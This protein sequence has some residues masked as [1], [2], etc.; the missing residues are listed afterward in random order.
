MRGRCSVS[1]NSPPVKSRP[2]PTAGRPPAAG[3]SARH[4]DP[5]AGNYSRPARSAGAAASAGPARRHGSAARYSSIA[6][7]E[8]DR[9]CR[10]PRAIG[11]RAGPVAR[12]GLRAKLLDQLRQRIGEIAILALPE[13]MPRHDDA[14]SGRAASS[15][16]GRDQRLRARRRVSSGPVVA[17][18]RW[19]ISVDDRGPS[20]GRR[21]VLSMVMRQHR[22]RACAV[23]S[24]CLPPKLRR[25]R[26][27]PSLAAFGAKRRFRLISARSG[28]GRPR[29]TGGS[30]AGR[31]WPRRRRSC[32]SCPGRTHMN[33]SSRDQALGPVIPSCRSSSS[34]PRGAVDDEVAGDEQHHLGLD[35]PALDARPVAG[36]VE[37]GVVG[38]ALMLDL[39]GRMPA[40]QRRRL[41]ARR[42][43]DGADRRATRARGSR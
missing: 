2:V 30:R 24:R 10:A 7:R 34:A 40:P 19:S 8:R 26:A 32:A 38:D 14:C 27:A 23:A 33:Q 31:I 5:G 21:C 18:P 29:S 13:A 20:R 42:R 43:R 9:R 37:P 28:G 17:Q 12:K 22:A 39:L 3:N 36:R 15:S 11:S 16:I 4:R 35:L 41:A 6:V 1:T 25:R